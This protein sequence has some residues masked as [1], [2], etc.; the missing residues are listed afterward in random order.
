MIKAFTYLEL[1]LVI[2]LTSIIVSAGY[3]A[4]SI[5]GK[6]N[7][8]LNSKQAKL[9]DLSLF[10]LQLKKAFSDADEM[11]ISDAQIVL[12]SPNGDEVK[13]RVQEGFISYSGSYQDSLFCNVLNP[14]EFKMGDKGQVAFEIEYMN[15]VFE[16][17]YFLE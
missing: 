4:I 5:L 12:S 16:L 14:V 11:Y 13:L 1:I 2:V 8:S 17:N 6:Q 15:Q 7:A 3:Y 9:H 10:D